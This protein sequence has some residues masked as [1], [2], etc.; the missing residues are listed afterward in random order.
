MKIIF[1]WVFFFFFCFLFFYF[2]WLCDQ[3]DTGFGYTGRIQCACNLLYALVKGEES[4]LMEYIWLRSYF[5]R[6]LTF[7]QV[8]RYIGL[9]LAIELPRP[10]AISNKNIPIDFLELKTEIAHLRSEDTFLQRIVTNRHKEVTFLLFMH[11]FRT[12][13]M[14]QNNHFYLFNSYSRDERGLGIAC[15]T[16]VLFKFLDLREFEKYM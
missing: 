16:S 3:S 15:G 5:N 8:I 6:G 7:V 10:V 4:A 13:L 9:L 14:K 11:G 1:T 12:T 2:F